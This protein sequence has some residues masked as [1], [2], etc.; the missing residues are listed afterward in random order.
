[1]KFTTFRPKAVTLTTSR[2]I[3]EYFLSNLR[4]YHVFGEIPPFLVNF[5]VLVKCGEFHVFRVFRVSGTVS[6]RSKKNPKMNRN[7]FEKFPSDL[8]KVKLICMFIT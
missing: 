6:F 3:I 2:E 1:M 7:F 5:T 4:N 8:K